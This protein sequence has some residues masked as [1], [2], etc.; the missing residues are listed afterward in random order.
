V[1]GGFFVKP[2]YATVGI[3]QMNKPNPNLPDDLP[4][5]A[6]AISLHNRVSMRVWIF[7]ATV[8]ILVLS[9]KPTGEGKV[10]KFLSISMEPST[11]YLVAGLVLGFTTITFCSARAQAMLA[12]KVFSNRLEDENASGKFY[13]SEYRHIAVAYLLPSPDLVRLYPLI[14]L[15]PRNFHRLA[16]LFLKV[17]LDVALVGLPWLGMTAAFLFVESSQ[18]VLP[19][20]G[21]SSL[22]TSILGFADWVLMGLWGVC[23]LAAIGVVFDQIHW[24]WTRNISSGD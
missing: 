19:T 3:C 6:D 5:L 12:S 4:M 9:A 17:P 7:A 18:F 8:S 14:R 23:S 2:I 16:Y 11:F 10:I 1:A 24:A 21:W 20:V 15:A 22:V 13:S